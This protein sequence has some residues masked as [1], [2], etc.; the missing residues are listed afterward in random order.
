MNL[1]LLPQSLVTHDGVEYA[2]ARLADSLRLMVS[3]DDGSVVL[4]TFNGDITSTTGESLLV[5]PL[6]PQNAAALRHQL[7][8]LKPL[9]LGAAHISRHG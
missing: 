3:A 2:L 1:H 9:P 5:G 6:N 4:S 7:P 8:W